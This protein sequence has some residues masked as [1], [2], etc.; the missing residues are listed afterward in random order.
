[1]LKKL[2]LA[3]MLVAPIA[4]LPAYAEEKENAQANKLGACSKE[5]AEKGLKGD[6]RN[7]YLSECAK[8]KKSQGQKLGACSKEAAKKGLK[9]D[10]RNKFMS[11]CGKS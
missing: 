8:A 6:E 9:G 3:A 2:L 1:M 5:A 11:D 4:T 7:K 10:E